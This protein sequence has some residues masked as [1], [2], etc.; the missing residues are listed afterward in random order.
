MWPSA[1]ALDTPVGGAD[2]SFEPEA[3]I[4]FSSEQSA[5]HR[6][7]SWAACSE[8]TRDKVPVLVDLTCERGDTEN[9]LSNEWY[10]SW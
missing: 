7:T 6:S 4:A 8:P 2:A 9:K 5:Y 3:R 10:V 1:Q